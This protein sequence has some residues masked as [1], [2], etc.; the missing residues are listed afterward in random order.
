MASF[1]ECTPETDFPLQNIPFG[2]FSTEDDV[3]QSPLP[4]SPTRAVPSESVSTTGTSCNQT[5]LVKP[6]IHLQPPWSRV[7]AVC[8]WPRTLASRWPAFLLQLSTLAT[9]RCKATRSSVGVVVVSA[10]SHNASDA[11]S[12]SADVAPCVRAC[13]PCPSWSGEDRTA[14]ITATVSTSSL[15]TCAP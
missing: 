14:H 13:I 11:Y 8:A 5:L 12:F 15:R 7:R 3:R 6:S 4:S 9:L 1:I 2:V 10:C